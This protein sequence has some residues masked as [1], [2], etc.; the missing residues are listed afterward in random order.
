MDI[1]SVNDNNNNKGND[2]SFTHHLFVAIIWNTLFIII[3]I[4]VLHLINLNKE[5]QIMGTRN[6]HEEE[7]RV[8]L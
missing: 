3:I 7:T 6:T 8:I 4:L 1:D 5:K 2:D